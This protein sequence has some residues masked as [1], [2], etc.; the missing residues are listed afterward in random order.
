L[1][2]GW[3]NDA[4]LSDQPTNLVHLGGATGGLKLD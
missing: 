2:T 1:N 4:I 3:R